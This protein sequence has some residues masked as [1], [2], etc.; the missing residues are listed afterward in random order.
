ML[1]Q[2]AGETISPHSGRRG[3]LPRPPSGPRPPFLQP[4][5]SGWL[6]TSSRV[7]LQE[8][9][10]TLPRVSLHP[11][12][13]RCGVHGGPAPCLEVGQHPAQACSLAPQ[14]TAPRTPCTHNFTTESLSWKTP[15]ETSCFRGEGGAA[16]RLQPLAQVR[17]IRKGGVRSKLGL[18][19]HRACALRPLPG[20]ASRLL[21]TGHAVTARPRDVAAE[22]C[23]VEVTRSARA[24]VSLWARR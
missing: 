1:P 12:T 16:E 18:C 2:P 22:R 4:L 3:V 9:P 11:K 21:H 14:S 8:L 6:T 10:L 20:A 19:V 5:G 23:W 13:S 17:A 15:A 24:R 7:P